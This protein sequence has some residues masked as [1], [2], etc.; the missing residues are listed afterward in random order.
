M[1]RGAGFTPAQRA[2]GRG[3][4]EVER[5]E[6]SANP[7]YPGDAQRPRKMSGGGFIP[8][9]RTT[10]Q[11]RTSDPG[12]CAPSTHQLNEAASSVTCRRRRVASEGTAP[13]IVFRKK[14]SWAS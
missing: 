4:R 13:E 2:G 6:T 12:G 5:S 7:A 3:G 9:P 1:K 10:R 11:R 8:T 14:R